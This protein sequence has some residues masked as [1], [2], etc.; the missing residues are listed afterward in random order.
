[1][2]IEYTKKRRTFEIVCYCGWRKSHNRLICVTKSSWCGAKNIWQNE[3]AKKH[4]LINNH[5][6]LKP[7]IAVLDHI[8]YMR[9]NGLRLEVKQMKYTTADVHFSSYFF[10][11]FSS[12]VRWLHHS[13]SSMNSM[14]NIYRR[15][16]NIWNMF[17]F[18]TCYVKTM[19]HTPWDEHN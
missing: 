7:K 4:T 14:R 15:A 19:A 8:I 9:D 3:E 5:S 18:D 12:F 6:V 13:A 16:Y 1:M 11:L 17:D 2:P 10:A